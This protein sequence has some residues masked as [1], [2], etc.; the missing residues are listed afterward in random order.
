MPRQVSNLWNIGTQYRGSSTEVARAWLLHQETVARNMA[1]VTQAMREFLTCCE[2]PYTSERLDGT[3]YCLRPLNGL[4]Y[5]CKIRD[6]A[7]V[8]VVGIS[9]SETGA[10]ANALRRVIEMPMLCMRLS[11]VQTIGDLSRLMGRDWG[12]AVVD[13]QI[14][15]A[16]GPAYRDFLR[17]N[18]E[19]NYAPYIN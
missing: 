8:E 12:L 11:T 3:I 18:L 7:A 6:E 1:G 13:W 15:P 4:A 5:L 9:L 2:P 10:M 17:T 16:H 19:G 14:V